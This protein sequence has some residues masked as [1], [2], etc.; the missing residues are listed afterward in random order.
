MEFIE[1]RLFWEGGV[2]R[3]DIMAAFQVSEPQASKDLAL[4]R[5][6]A[7]MNA[8]YDGSTRRY[9]AA[10]SFQ[11]VFLNAGP[12][13]YL[14][15]L[16]LLAEG[17]IDKDDT[18]LGDHP[19]YDVVVTPTRKVEPEC[20]REILRANRTVQSIE[21]LY[22]SMSG[23]RRDP[24]WRRITPHAMGFDGFRWHTRAF[25]HVTDAFKDFLLPRIIRTRDF[26]PPGRLGE[27]DVQWNER[28]T[29]LLKP[30]PALGA[31][32][33]A[34]VADDYGMVDGCVSVST[35]CAMLF[36]MLKRLGLL[37][38]AEALP[39]RSQH[40]V[41]ANPEETAAALKKAGFQR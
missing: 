6:R 24:T 18:W 28:F 38:D 9:V 20:L 29:V 11:P 32:Q 3:S 22:Q 5:A 21:V 26:G 17:L 31:N 7:P 19:A 36:Y 14:Q 16:R 25:C 40:V 23:E 37:D 33:A 15:R 27:E 1:F 8:T 35:R 2:Q 12:D 34:T 41:L 30:H 10:E 13:E 4:Y 39:A